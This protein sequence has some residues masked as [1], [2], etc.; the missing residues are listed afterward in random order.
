MKITFVGS[1]NV[2]WQLSLAMDRAGHN[3]EQIISRNEDHAK[4]LAVKFGAHYSTDP[5]AI[6]DLVDLVILAVPDDR[7]AEVCAELPSVNGVL[8][9]T[10]GVRSMEILKGGAFRYGVIYPLQ[11]L[12]KN[13]DVDMLRVPFLI[14]GSDSNATSILQEIAGDISNTVRYCSS[15]D[16]ANYHL[17]AVFANNF[18]NVLYSMSDEFLKTKELDFDMLK[19]LIEQTG[20]KLDQG[21]PMEQQTG[22]AMRGDLQTMKEHL[23]ML[24][25]RPE[26]VEIYRVLSRAIERRKPPH[27]N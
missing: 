8:V 4:A 18:A 9:H 14:E 5:K 20:R 19:P 13:V 25:D 12:N 24:E 21:T 11:T 17:A 16:R 1:G 10:C 7:I 27:N 6:Y 3:I 23:Q 15:S 2:A 22:P 26:F